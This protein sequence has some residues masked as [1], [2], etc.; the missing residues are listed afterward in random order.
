[1]GKKNHKKEERK[2]SGRSGLHITIG[3]LPDQKLEP[4]KKS[5]EQ[6][7]LEHELRLVK[8]ALLYADQV[9]LCSITTS[10][11]LPL[12]GGGKPNNQKP[13]DFLEEM[14]PFVEPLLPP[15]EINALIDCCVDR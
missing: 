3:S 7:S 11:I 5:L 2:A 13:E 14:I 12:L 4:S 8:A 10:M 1:M 15:H 6:I 9:T